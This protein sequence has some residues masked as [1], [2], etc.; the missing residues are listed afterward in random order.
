MIDLFETIGYKHCG[1]WTRLTN[2]QGSTG[3]ELWLKYR[4]EDIYLS[5]LKGPLVY[6]WT[7]NEKIIYVGVS[8]RSIKTRMLD[9]EGGFRGG[10]KSG[11]ERQASI[12]ALNQNRFDVYVAFK[13]LFSSYLKE[14]Q[15]QIIKELL[16]PID[17]DIDF[18]MKRE[19][20]LLIGIL[21][22]VL[23]KR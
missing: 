11:V 2:H 10:S 21:N 12:L 20:N 3:K 23:N 4:A 8:S 15:N 9:H 7:A 14:K 1:Y 19:E 5:N 13:P 22:P 16:S 6:I 18:A 17:D